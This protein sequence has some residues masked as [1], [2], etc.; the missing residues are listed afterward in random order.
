MR[1]P[2]VLLVVW[3]L[4]SQAVVCGQS[5]KPGVDSAE[6][7][8]FNALENRHIS[9]NEEKRLLNLTGKEFEEAVR[10]LGYLKGIDSIRYVWVVAKNFNRLSP[11]RPPATMDRA[12]AA[13]VKQMDTDDVNRRLQHLNNLEGVNHPRFKE[14]A[15]KL[16]SSEDDYT[17]RQA[18]KNLE[19][20]RALPEP[21]T[22]AAKKSESPQ[23]S[24]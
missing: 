12:A 21:V 18:K 2:P 8:P 1:L 5:G 4:V 14:L 17:A 24:K 16:S 22:P 6:I 11:D 15:Q 13:I 10:V 19:I 9:A 23:E 3:S 20:L 7:N